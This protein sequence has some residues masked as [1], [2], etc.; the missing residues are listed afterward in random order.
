MVGGDAGPRW[1]RRSAERRPS[2]TRRRCVG[3][4]FCVIEQNSH[5]NIIVDKAKDEIFS[6]C[7]MSMTATTRSRAASQ[8]SS[9]GTRTIR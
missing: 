2:S 1:H 5:N 7:L 4:P 6:A 3:V 8:G 9:A